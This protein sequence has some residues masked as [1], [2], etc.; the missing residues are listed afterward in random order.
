MTALQHRLSA[1]WFAD[2]VGYSRLASEDETAAL[3][4]VELGLSLTRGE[5]PHLTLRAGSP[6]WWM[7][8]C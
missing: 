7:S 4:L 6:Y 5:V 3:H 8:V 2:I 1:V